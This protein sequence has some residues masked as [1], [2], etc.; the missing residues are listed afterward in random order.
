MNNIINYLIIIGIAIIA[1]CIFDN[2]KIEPMMLEY[3]QGYYPP[4]DLEGGN[5]YDNYTGK[6]FLNEKYNKLPK[7]KSEI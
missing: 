5:T 6:F 7:V 2:I 1:F 3:C 4:Y